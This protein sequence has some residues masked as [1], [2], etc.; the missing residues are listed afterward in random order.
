MYS[1][2]PVS[3]IS[4]IALVQKWPFILTSEAYSEEV[5]EFKVKVIWEKIHRNGDPWKCPIY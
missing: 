5:P 1:G 4:S 2:I 3:I